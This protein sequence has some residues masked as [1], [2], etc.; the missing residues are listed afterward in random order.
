MTTPDTRSEN[1]V[2]PD[3]LA[4]PGR[5]G[6]PALPGPVPAR[7]GAGEARSKAAARP[8]VTP[9]ADTAPALG[10]FSRRHGSVPGVAA[11][12]TLL[13]G[14]LNV[15]SAITPA[16]RSR[17]RDVNDVLP[18]ALS[19]SA[20][21]LTLVFGILL[22]LLARALR[23]RKRRAWRATVVL[24]AA[25][26]I[27][28]IAKGLDVEEAIIAFL[29]LL[30]LVLYRRDFYAKGDPTTRWR[31]LWYGL[32]LLAASIV[33][34]MALLQFRVHRMV[35]PHPL[36]AQFEHVLRGLVGF[37]GPLHFGREGVDDLVA[38]V[39]GGLGLFTVLAVVYLALR[40]PEPR[41]MLT[42]EDETRMRQL[43][44]GPHGGRDSLGYFALRRDKSVVWSPTKKAAI[45]Y[46]VVSG[47][48]LASGD[49]L[50]DPEAWPGAI[51]E[52]MMLADEHAWT[53]A[54]IGCSE[55]GG[56]AYARVAGLSALEFGD[57]AVIEL[58]DFS[59]DGRAMRNVRQAFGR[60]ER[61]GYT[62]R[63][64]RSADIT[65]DDRA[66]L[67]EQAAAWRGSETERGFS[68]ALG[69]FGDPED[70]QCAAVMAFDAEG[71]LRGFLHFVPWG[72]DG[73]SLDLMRR[74]RDAENGIN[75]FLIVSALKAA[76]QLEVTKVSLNFAVF[77]SALERGE[78][79]GAG[80]ILRAWRGL[81]VF[82]SRWFQ[83]DSLYRFN[84]KFR[85]IWE[86]RF[87][88]Y[89]SGRDLPRIAIAMLEAEAFIVWPKPTLRRAARQVLPSAADAG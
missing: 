55:A 54:V 29:L 87:V 82:L 44:A 60:P 31:A 40:P 15:L 8:A 74:D 68:M 14:V 66:Q 48:I 83:I 57:E 69:R 47:V 84:A 42:A 50:G 51:K 58:A 11:L 1:T 86:P 59:L 37:D 4:A 67:R 52:F 62:A 30:A 64:A 12:L 16:L 43:L 25:S 19:H 28:H 70:G 2:G 85:P 81:L 71:K 26:T 35:G 22:I 76:P 33:I 3:P 73:L 63:V 10:Y 88:C 9:P 23:R 56:T 41:A 80:P 61:A 32:G 7:D 36:S 53:P 6:K 79:L 13:A 78:R 49:P 39:L 34:G 24:L 46:R 75:E 20:A 65:S 89:P 21:A 17:A 72:Q 27:S 77:R 5:G 38:R 18:G 45:A